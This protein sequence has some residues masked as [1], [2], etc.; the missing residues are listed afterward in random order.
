MKNFILLFFAVATFITC[1]SKVSVEE[2]ETLP[3][4]IALKP[5]DLIAQQRD[6]DKLS[7]LIKEID[8]LI[9][10]ETCTGIDNWAYSPI[11]AKPCGGPSSYIAY[12]K[13][14]EAEI[15]PKI[16]SFTAEQSA[17]NAK[18][19]LMSDCALVPEPTAMICAN[20]KAVLQSGT[21]DVE[22]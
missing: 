19:D 10:T 11:G 21:L 7:N 17:F 15:L 4:D 14:K 3:K 13:N 9:A 12:P 16:S 8:S 20:G 6:K 5:N 1:K 2:V 18:Y 22:N